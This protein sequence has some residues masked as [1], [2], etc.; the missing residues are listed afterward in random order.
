M[1]E[2][3]AAGFDAAVLSAALDAAPQVIEA[4]HLMVVEGE[5]DDIGLA[6]GRGEGAV[7]SYARGFLS[8]TT[9][10]AITNSA[11]AGYLGIPKR[12]IMPDV[13]SAA[14]SFSTDVILDSMRL[15][16]GGITR[17][18]LADSICEDA[19]IMT[20]ELIGGRVGYSV[21][22]ATI[23]MPSVGYA[24]GSF[25]GSAIGG[26]LWSAFQ[27]TSV[28]ARFESGLPFFEPC[29]SGTVVSTDALDRA[30]ITAFNGDFL[31]RRPYGQRSS[32]QSTNTDF[33]SIGVAQLRKG[34]FEVGLGVNGFT[35]N[36]LR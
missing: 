10:A 14:A 21:G 1:R 23:K 13:I 26:M 17:A 32:R 28:A 2:S 31:G 19:L 4:A 7:T 15:A 11:R 22:L 33:D 3:L 24:L 16:T 6:R 27:R 9:A 8:G 20:C 30:G 29:K 5:L 12:L 35:W 25:V 34:V 18:E 36:D